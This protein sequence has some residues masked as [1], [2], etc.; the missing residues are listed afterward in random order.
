MPTSAKFR[1]SLMWAGDEA[2]RRVGHGE[3]VM[4]PAWP[5]RGPVECRPVTRLREGIGRDG[6][7]RV[8]GEWGIGGED[9]N[10]QETKT[11]LVRPVLLGRVGRS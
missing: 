2:R 11:G 7:D 3:A 8:A 4:W 5:A 10:R 6:A 9:E 1:V